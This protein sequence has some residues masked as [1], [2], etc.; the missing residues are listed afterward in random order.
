MQRKGIKN[1]SFRLIGLTL[2]LEQKFAKS[3]INSQ[4]TP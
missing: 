2:K 3:Y 4:Q 1:S